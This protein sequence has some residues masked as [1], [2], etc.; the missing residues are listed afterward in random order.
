MI[1]LLPPSETK[2]EGGDPL[3]PLQLRAL[4]F[5]RL[6]EAR[7]LAISALEAIADDRDASVRA[8]KLGTKNVAEA[9]RNAVLRSSPTMPAIDRYD[10][11]LYDALDPE[12]LTV[13][14]R[15][16]AAGHLV[17]HSALFGLVRALDP[18]PAYRLSHDSRVPGLR[19]RANWAAPISAALAEHDG[20][21]IDAR[22]E[23]YAS[24][25]PVDRARRTVFIRVVAAGADGRRRALNHFNKKAKGEFARALMAAEVVLDDVDALRDWAASA[26]L[27][28]ES[29]EPGELQLVV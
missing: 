14:A 23:G 29:G 8:L 11:V 15:A 28:L 26:R 12:S 7:R 1:L 22:S 13:S 5:P 10:G 19:L 17:V 6:T 2:R 4:G 27:R 20:L 21:V 24:L 16:F 18:I 25:G 9:D 3:H